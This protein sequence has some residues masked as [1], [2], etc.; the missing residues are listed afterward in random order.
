M[1]T[2]LQAYYITKTNLGKA[3]NFGFDFNASPDIADWWECSI[4]AIVYYSSFRTAYYGAIDNFSKFS[5]NASTTNSFVLNAGKTLLA[6]LNFEYQASNQE[7]VRIQFATANLNGGIKALFFNKKLTVSLE[8]NDLFA[9]D[10]YHLKNLVNN[11][12]TNSYY[13]DRELG[14]SLTYKFGNGKAKA[15]RQRNSNTEESKRA[16]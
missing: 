10:R 15:I 3:T 14:F 9:T 11:A 1:D 13:D 16:G 5:W 2:A 7:N 12:E 8:F 4:N 6:E